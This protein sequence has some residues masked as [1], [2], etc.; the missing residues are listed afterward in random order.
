MPE[1]TV[2]NARFRH[3]R[4]VRWI[5]QGGPLRGEAYVPLVTRDDCPGCLVCKRTIGWFMEFARLARDLIG[6]NLRDCLHWRNLYDN[7]QPLIVPASNLQQVNR[8]TVVELREAYYAIPEEG[9]PFLEEVWPHD[10]DL[11]QGER[12]EDRLA[13]VERMVELWEDGQYVGWPS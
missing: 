8:R 10:Q 1:L 12:F 4:S 3:Y 13:I 9:R 11:S 2:N 5:L 7:P 6:I